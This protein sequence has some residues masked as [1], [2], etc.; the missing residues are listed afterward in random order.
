[1]EASA[2]RA[3]ERLTA[4][5]TELEAGRAVEWPALIDWL[6]NAVTE[7]V[8][9]GQAGSG[10][11]G[12]P[13]DMGA[14]ELLQRI[15]REVRLMR[16]ALYLP[17]VKDTK[18]AIR[19][20]WATACTYRASGS[21]D[22]DQQWERICEA[23]PQWVAWITQEWDDRTRIMEV[24][25]PCPVCGERWILED[26]NGEEKRRSAIVVE[27]SEGR[28]PSAECRAAECG[29][30]W[31]GWSAVAKLGFTLGAQQNLEILKACGIDLGDTIAAS[32]QTH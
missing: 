19:G 29:G 8:K 10:G 7:Q 25:V 9:R 4:D 1:M 16:E 32:L 20:A 17:V 2:A 12:A 13:I 30:F 28:A 14:L 31:V 5:H 22:D 3:V 11:A 6:D 27:Y 21:L 23:P 15:E 26:V 18:A 24:T